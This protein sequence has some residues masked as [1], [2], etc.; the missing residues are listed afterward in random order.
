MIYLLIFTLSISAQL[1]AYQLKKKCSQR[2]L[3]SILIFLSLLIPA[4]LAGV[5]ANSVGTDMFYYAI[6]VFEASDKNASNFSEFISYINFLG[7]EHGYAIM[8]FF[9]VKIF[10]N[11]EVMLLVDNFIVIIFVYL[12]LKEYF[13]N[14]P[15][16]LGMLT[17]YLLLYNDSLN[18]MRQSI[19]LSMVFYS[20]MLLMNRKYFFSFAMALLA[21]GFHSTAILSFFFLSILWGIN[22]SKVRKYVVYIISF[23]AIFLLLKLEDIAALIITYVPFLAARSY[24]Y[25]KYL[26]QLGEY[27]ISLYNCFTFGLIFLLLIITY[28][29]VKQKD[30][31]VIFFITIYIFLLVML[32]STS[33]I[34]GRIAFYFEIFMTVIIMVLQEIFTGSSKK[35][36]Q[37]GIIGLLGLSWVYRVI[38]CN[39]G[40][41]FPYIFR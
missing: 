9:L 16:W 26:S 28:K 1:V 3:Y 35:L 39:Y 34:L 20:I 37:I 30:Q 13:H 11:I 17:F 29:K 2:Y 18:I 14:K 24:K 32:M 21:T 15:V 7:I 33:F 27:T 8:N 12:G 23:I 5:R 4:W 41:T 36:Y 31:N 25:S 6:R 10:H 38:L 19:A 40:E 22:T